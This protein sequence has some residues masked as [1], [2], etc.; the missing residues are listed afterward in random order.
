MNPEIANQ[1]NPEDGQPSGYEDIAS[2]VPFAGEQNAQ[3]GEKSPEERQ[4]EDLGVLF[5]FCDEKDILDILKSDSY[6][7]LLENNIS[8]V[9]LFNANALFDEQYYGEGFT[10]DE[11]RYAPEIA[12]EFG[13]DDS[14]TK[15]E[16]KR[17]DRKF[18]LGQVANLSARFEADGEYDKAAKI[19]DA[20]YEEDVIRAKDA[21]NTISIIAEQYFSESSSPEDAEALRNIISLRANGGELSQE[22]K[23]FLRQE[24]N[25]VTERLLYN[26]HVVNEER[27]NDILVGLEA[28]LNEFNSDMENSEDERY[29]EIYRGT[30]V[31]R[32]IFAKESIDD[33]LEAGRPELV[34]EAQK[35]LAEMV[36]DHF[37]TIVNTD[38]TRMNDDFKETRLSA[39]ESL[40]FEYSNP[41]ELIKRAERYNLCAKDDSE[42]TF[43]I[44]NPDKILQTIVDRWDTYRSGGSDSRTMY[45]SHHV[46]EMKSLGISDEA[47]LENCQPLNANEFIDSEYGKF[48][49]VALLEAGVD[50]QKLLSKI[51]CSGAYDPGPFED[52]GA[53]NISPVDVLAQKS[54]NITEIAQTF[55]PNDISKNLAEFIKRGADAKEL[56]KYMMSYREKFEGNIIR[57]AK[58]DIEGYHAM[59]FDGPQD[60]M[61]WDKNHPDGRMVVKEGMAG[62]GEDYVAVNLDILASNGVTEE[63]IINEMSGSSANPDSFFIYKLL[64]CDAFD[65]QK[66]ITACFEKYKEH[67]NA[68]HEAGYYDEEYV[69][70]AADPNRYYS[71]I[72]KNMADARKKERQ[73]KYYERLITA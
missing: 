25:P 17:N 31:S 70:A 30:L 9:D 53:F 20:G 45:I 32:M 15:L 19:M 23:D 39:V 51:F 55:T 3:N 2:E 29:A 16:S 58:G 61:V 1:T 33:F 66:T 24:S 13:I 64:E 46:S 41:F 10:K 35:R 49:G 22:Q 69:K 71:L 37:E 68:M 28:G 56:M 43:K 27:A 57:D 11:W 21:K 7:V 38:F 72:I 44:E 62:S 18:R 12:A 5:S 73:A 47:I 26:G 42:E 60:V 54:F 4:V 6:G 34:A 14:E 48:D 59:W 63:E 40:V 65:R 52:Y 67:L 50:R 36:D 8:L